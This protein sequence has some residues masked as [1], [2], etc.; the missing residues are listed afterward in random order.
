MEVKGC[1]YGLFDGFALFTINKRIKSLVEKLFFFLS[2]YNKSKSYF[3]KGVQL[4]KRAL[5]FSLFLPF[6][7]IQKKRET[8]EKG[9]AKKQNKM[10][11][12]KNVGNMI[13]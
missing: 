2:V 4:P 13:C 7:K 6:Q 5:F 10:K 11:E 8:K 3:H 1:P 12:T 9:N